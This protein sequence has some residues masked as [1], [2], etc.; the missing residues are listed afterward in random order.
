MVVPEHHGIAEVLHRLGVA[1]Q[2]G[3]RAQKNFLPLQPGDVPDT[4]ADVSA[5]AADL[6]YRPSITV[7]EGIRRF[8]AWYRDY[9]G[10]SD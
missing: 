1:Q 5:L 3:K 10:V 9:Y 4:D 7:E 6:D 2:L 8:V